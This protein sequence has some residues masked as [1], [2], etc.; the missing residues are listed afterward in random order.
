[1][2]AKPTKELDEATFNMKR[3]WATLYDAPL[4]AI[5]N[6]VPP[7]DKLETIHHYAQFVVCKV[8]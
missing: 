7:H 3:K 6:M 8:A 2:D 5:R 1:M 4:A